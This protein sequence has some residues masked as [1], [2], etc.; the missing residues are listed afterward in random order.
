MAGT[1]KST[2][3]FSN[4]TRRELE[5]LRRADFASANR[6]VTVGD[7]GLPFSTYFTS[8]GSTGSFTGTTFR[9]SRVADF[10]ALGILVGDQL[11]VGTGSAEGTYL[12]TG[13]FVDH[14]TVSPGT[15]ATSIGYTLAHPV[16][17]IG[18]GNV[19][20]ES[21]ITAPTHVLDDIN[22]LTPPLNPG[23]L[24]GTST[25]I[26]A[27]SESVRWFGPTQIADGTQ[28]HTALGGTSWIDTTLVT[29]FIGLGV[30]AGDILLIKGSTIHHVNNNFSA[31][32]TITGVAATTLTLDP[33]TINAPNSGVP[34]LI[35]EPPLV[36]YSYLIVRPTVVQ[37]FA[38]P[39]SGPVGQ[40]QTFLAV[41]P[42][43]SLHSDPA[44]SLDDINN[45]RVPNLV[46]PR[47]GPPNIDRADAV[48]ASPAPRGS[49]DDLGYRMV[50]Y[51]SNGL[52][53]G[54]DL[55]KP[56]TTPAPVIDPNVPLTDQ[57]MTID[58][59]AGAIRFS[60]AP[61][62]G[63]NIKVNVGG[64]DPTTK[65][66]NLYA[67]FWAF[68]QTFTRGAARSLYNTRSDV[69]DSRSPARI[70]YDPV[71]DF[72]EIGQ[73]LP[74]S[75]GNP[76]TNNVVF[77][78]PPPN[79]D[80]RLSTYF[81]AYDGSST[82]Y[83][84]R[85]FVYRQGT[86]Y[87]N[88]W[89]FLRND[90]FFGD[91]PSTMEM[92]VGE[93]LALTTADITSPA[94]TPADFNPT[95]NFEPSALGRGARD[96]SQ[97]LQAALNAAL[98]SGYGKV[99]LR[100]GKYYI[101]N[102]IVVP[103]GVII[104]G[105]G[106]S[107]VVESKIT[108]TAPNLTTTPV[109][110]FGPN[111][112]WGVYDPTQA[113]GVGGTTVSPTVFDYST[114]LPPARMEGMDTVW[115]PVRRVWAVVWADVTQSAIWFNEVR[116]DGT[117]VFPGF[118]VDIK[119][120]AA[121][122]FTS[123]SPNSK[124]HTPGH[125]P[126]IALQEM[127]DEYAVVWVQEKTIAGP[128]TGPEVRLTM[129]RV[130][131]LVADPTATSPTGTP[132]SIVYNYPSV[133]GDNSFAQVDPATSFSDH[134]SVA[135]PSDPATGPA[136]LVP[137]CFWG[138]NLPFGLNTD[139]GHSRVARAY[140]SSFFPT[141]LFHFHDY[142]D[143]YL[144]ISSTDIASDGAGAGAGG[145]YLFVWSKRIHQ[146]ITGTVGQINVPL[147]LNSPIPG[148]PLS[149]S[150][151]VDGGFPVWAN[152][153]VQVG[154]KFIYL[155]INPPLTNT[156]FDDF[157]SIVA[158]RLSTSYGVDG[159]IVSLAGANAE[160]RTNT[161]DSYSPA[162]GYKLAPFTFPATA[163]IAAPG[164]I[165]NDIG[166]N[167]VFTADHI[168]PGDIAIK[169]DGIQYSFYR[170]DPIGVIDNTHVKLTT[171]ITAAVTFDY[172]ID[173]AQPFNWAIVPQTVIEGK[174]FIGTGIGGGEIATVYRYAGYPLTPVSYQLDPVEPDFV[175]VSKGGD[176]FL[177][178]YQ[179]MDT[180][181]LLARDQMG[182]FLDSLDSISGAT[183][184]FPRFFLRDHTAPYRHH[185]ATC[186]VMAGYDGSPVGPTTSGN[187]LL[188]NNSVFT[189]HAS[190]DLEISNRSLG[191]RDP[192]TYRPNFDTGDGRRDGQNHALQVSGLNF[193][194]KWDTVSATKMLPSLLPDVTW[195]GQ[196]WV[197]VSPT[198]NK[199]HSFTGNYFVDGGGN[200]HLGD[201]MFYFGLDTTNVT[202][203]AFLHR[204]VAIGDKIIFPNGG[205]PKTGTISSVTSEHTVL[206]VEKDV[207]LLNK[208]LGQF[209]QT[210]WVMA[211]IDTVTA[212]FGL[213]HLGFRVSADGRPML[214]SSHLTFADELPDTSLIDP[215]SA[216]PARTELMQ[217]TGTATSNPVPTDM[218]IDRAFLQAD[219]AAIIGGGHNLPGS[220]YED[221][222]DP[223]ARYVGNVTFRGV[224]PGEPV[225]CN[226]VAL[227][228]PPMCAIA[229]GENMYGFISRMVSGTGHKVNKVSFYRQSFGPYNSGIRDLKII[230]RN[231]PLLD[232]TPLFS[233]LKT[234]TRQ[235]V[236]T[237]HGGPTM[238][239]GFFAT[240]GFRNFFAYMG[241]KSM[242][243]NGDIT[244]SPL[245]GQ[246]LPAI[247]GVYTNATGQNPILTAGPDPQLHLGL[248]GMS[249]PMSEMAMNE[250]LD[251]NNQ[252]G[253]IWPS[254]PRVIWDGHQYVVAWLEGG[255]QGEPLFLCL[256]TFPGDEDTGLQTQ[257]MVDSR[258]LQVLRKT[259]QAVQLNTRSQGLVNP[260]ALV[261]NIDLAFS[262][263]TYAV[264]WSL[265]Y[266]AGGTATAAIGVTLFEA[267]GFSGQEL[268]GFGP[269]IQGG[270]NASTDG[271]N[272]VLTD[273][274]TIAGTPFSFRN[275]SKG[276]VVII[277][278]GPAAGRYFVTG[279]PILGVS[280]P[281]D[282]VPPL[283]A[284]VHYTIHHPLKPSG[285]ATYTIATSNQSGGRIDAFIFPKVIWDG[286][287]F[288]CVW[289]SGLYANNGSTTPDTVAQ[290]RQLS[291]LLMPEMG[292]AHPQEIMAM[293]GDNQSSVSTMLG[294][295]NLDGIT[296]LVLAGDGV[297]GATG[298]DG[299]TFGTTDF[300]S[301]TGTFVTKGVQPGFYV[302]IKDNG[303]YRI[304]DVVSQ[305]ELTLSSNAPANVAQV[306]EVYRPLTTVVKAGD[307]VVTTK[308]NYDGTD[309]PN[310]AGWFNVTNVDLRSGLVS[311]TGKIFTPTV[312]IADTRVFGSI[313]NAAGRGDQ[314]QVAGY[315]TDVST[316][317]R[318]IGDMMTIGTVS[319]GSVLARIDRIHGFAYNELDDEFAV[320]F[321]GASS[322]G[323]HITSFKRGT[324]Q[325]RG[326]V[327]IVADDVR[328]AS[329]A[330][331]GRHYLVT[332]A[333]EF[334]IDDGKLKWA[335]INR[336]LTIETTGLVNT[337]SDVTGNSQEQM[338]GSPYGVLSGTAVVQ[339]RWRNVQ[340][341]W[342]P[343]LS[344]WVVAASLLWYDI[345]EHKK[346]SPVGTNE[347]SSERR[348]PTTQITGIVRNVLTV[349][350]VVGE[351]NLL[352]VGCKLGITQNASVNRYQTIGTI[353]AINAAGPNTITLNTE[354][355]EPALVAALPVTNH[356]VVLP[357]EDC[358]VWTLGYDS[359]VI[360]IEDADGVFVENV[361]ISGGTADI[362]EKYTHLAMPS[363]QSGGRPTISTTPTPL[364]DYNVARESQYNHI[365][366]SP[367]GKMR[368]ARFTNVQSTTKMRHGYTQTP[369]DPA[370][371][372]Y[373]WGGKSR[374][375]N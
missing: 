218:A 246:T 195:T 9:D 115:N 275:V 340:T 45:D 39:G 227:T 254:A 281:I 196:D 190:R 240:D 290:S 344:R 367:A 145:G 244:A 70:L 203:Q 31:V 320:L 71:Q 131:P 339:P 179:A 49:L 280:A 16:T 84:F 98:T 69:I 237:R 304:I 194:H 33:T 225:G 211:R 355:F 130:Q 77:R 27:P 221:I 295:I 239:N 38:V 89:K 343:R 322:H 132:A 86:G 247:F 206:L 362:E 319:T 298:V 337:L 193:L 159:T 187:A 342:N 352:Q 1:F 175:R 172:R 146:L 165:L 3:S 186:Y 238:A 164:D 243:R 262:G 245:T 92:D 289:R 176:N 141:I 20:A 346:T 94:M 28:G 267:T 97:T 375:G 155:G 142:D 266:D 307:T 204:T 189:S 173:F 148:A 133:G 160:I 59:K 143:H 316:S 90:I 32:A 118:G 299:Q 95:V 345:N 265:G 288:V 54:P 19:L 277:P 197:V 111:T 30:Q 369:E 338:P 252:V 138:F 293:N 231:T 234:L 116:P 50:L 253:P 209:P 219:S 120:T 6:T 328:V 268:D 11:A 354:K 285:A 334:G 24:L 150:N 126:R 122:L 329:L 235:Y 274:N 102:T 312:G 170:V 228:E 303:I 8:S 201:P 158:Q 241:Q 101:N 250:F 121:L 272:A 83:F 229:W 256:S 87:S 157:T 73:S 12:V 315:G 37:L 85:H 47:F 21:F 100:R 166:V 178:V 36:H 66:L 269:P 163:V 374:K 258:D 232:N 5:Q 284:G 214:M 236:Y 259:A 363:W 134:P 51:P 113:P 248:T 93:K 251:A 25:Q 368:T 249:E 18:L 324:M 297:P 292:L 308:T 301:A 185:V 76:T 216:L 46:D 78:A 156:N 373:A 350:N 29:N 198:K 365:F 192:I 257:E 114:S 162:S 119:H 331:N 135:L 60:C 200:V 147:G 296:D 82:N 223:G 330:W 151:F 364:H 104:E 333:N 317:P 215:A 153:G 180:T 67:T 263:K 287:Q 357:R 300:Q 326:E 212:P 184:A 154:S 271:L 68:D 103:P 199:I 58:Y 139:A 57:Q 353:V 327:P 347:L 17:T 309:N 62:I 7:S 128:I 44:P 336:N 13:I 79:E 53:T 359:P 366:L 183:D 286:Q 110:K 332:Y 361:Q 174:R 341:Q 210:E 224:A 65:R 125:Y 242:V 168:L 358:V 306:Y 4:L 161:G 351:F 233:A 10:T 260:G 230:G 318:L 56:I 75:I 80:A 127:T 99:H 255:H 294:R 81:G 177:V 63:G 360:Q 372:R 169:M 335:L 222:L 349:T 202:D 88:Q 23:P 96:S 311:M 42:T 321:A 371:Q 105:E 43:S 137:V 305:T 108:T 117:S 55:T 323:L 264:L 152:V 226:E 310:D 124:N 356:L 64:V 217:R 40:E 22:T 2:S 220:T 181:G 123:T 213:K 370:Y 261:G 109:F 207:A 140:S 107:T 52:G 35:L 188:Q 144:V 291:Y 182:S 282:R 167:P 208:G 205:V 313:L 302:G 325:V 171:P 273:T 91:P 112:P 14:L 276:D 106:Y 26:A 74:I 279:S 283:S 314:S 136:Y 270:S 149:P 348:L 48:Y 41:L 34:V 72:W 15:T 129:F 191:A 61:A 278:T